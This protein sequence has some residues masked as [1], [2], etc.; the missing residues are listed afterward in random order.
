MITKNV[1]GNDISQ[2]FIDEIRSDSPN[3]TV[4]LLANGYA[5]SCDIVNVTIKKG[6]C[7]NATFMIGCVVGDMITA[8]VKN[9]DADIKGEELECQIGALV[10]GAYEYIS[11]GR[12]TVSEV[13]KTRYQQE[14]TAYSGI[15]SKTGIP[16]QPVTAVTPTIAHIGA[17][18]AGQL[19]CNV[20]FDEEIDTTL[21]ITASMDD[22]TVYNAIEVLAICCGGYAINNT[23]GDILIKRYS[24]T[25]DLDVDTGMMTRLPEIAEQPYRI[26]SVSCEVSDATYDEEGNPVSAVYLSLQD[27][28][29]QTHTEKYLMTHDGKFLLG[30]PPTV[31]DLQL[32][33]KY[34]TEE[35]FNIN[36][37]S[38]IGYEYYPATV[39]L[40]LGD[41]RLE[42][43][44]VMALADV[45]ET[46]Y[47]V[48]CHQI[49]HAYSNT[50]V[51]DITS[52]PA[53]DSANDIGTSMPI[54]E[55]LDRVERTADA[56]NQTAGSAVKIAGDTKQHFWFNG[57]G[58]DTGA[59]ITEVSEKDWND[60]T[61]P[62][63]HV[64]GNLLARSNGVACRDGMDE[65]AVFSATEIRIGKSTEGNTAMVS[66]GIE[67]RDGST[68][69]AQF[70]ADG[71]QIGKD[72][73][74]HVEITNRAFKMFDGTSADTPY[75]WLSD[76]RDNDGNYTATDKFVR[77]SY[78]GQQ[79]LV[80]NFTPI[81]ST[82]KLTA[83]GEVYDR[84]SFVF[85]W[86]TN[87][88]ITFSQAPDAGQTCVFTYY[89]NGQTQTYSFTTDGSTTAYAT[90]G[91]ILYGGY[92]ISVT[93]NGTA[94]AGIGF[95]SASITLYGNYFSEGTEITV[96]YKTTSDKTK[97]FTL[98]SR[99]ENTPIG[100]MSFSTGEGN[101]SSG[102]YS[103]SIGLNNIAS[104]RYSYAEGRSTK[105]TDEQA[106][107]EGY[108]TEALRSCAHAEGYITVANASYSHAEGK[109][110]LTRGEASHA[111]GE[112]TQAIGNF[113]HAEGDRCVASGYASHAGGYNTIASGYVQTVIGQYNV[114]HDTGGYYF[115]VG[116]GSSSTPKDA[117]ALTEYALT[118]SGTY[119]QSSDRRLKEHIDYLGDE[120]VEFVRSLK[121]AHYTKDGEHHVG[122][123]AQDVEEADKWDCMTGEM[124]GYKTLGY[125]ELIAPLVAYV[126]KLENRIEELERREEC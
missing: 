18:I 6:S 75:V 79:Y 37:K 1:N 13:K 2:G 105:A 118:I 81:P 9:L 46:V 98:G 63:Y 89:K 94:V 91:D 26:G 40:T 103:A 28:Y 115:V 97:A 73:D 53:D 19:Y 32:S 106:H 5:L 100:A 41:P 25:T 119:Q 101:E 117:L 48:P 121:P 4:K 74:T 110:T 122:F 99:A 92:P 3:T 44:D 82:E 84:D 42:G 66:D 20:N 17:R 116:C 90:P 22:L 33:S 93:L 7:G 85:V 112:Y 21:E 36:I 111:E 35:I 70:G 52:A 29:L 126:Q 43:C 123:Y 38:I 108:S 49:T 125:M 68:T 72:S 50:V 10:N 113:S 59:H 102:Q 55:R 11:V 14:I 83:L 88:T 60:S 12:F 109:Q 69:L 54:T 45:D 51:S 107:A 15:V 64:G 80:L 16:F 120:A 86:S 34:V 104:G 67:I 95:F 124:N 57:E 27:A 30:K 8:I 31:A 58:T 87:G 39:H 56:S 71:A 65:L 23:A 77:S 114:E 76:L 24:D 47:T 62:Y 96:E 61:S 78:E